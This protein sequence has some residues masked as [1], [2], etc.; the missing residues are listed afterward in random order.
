[1]PTFSRSLFV[2]AMVGVMAL[3]GC[4]KAPSADAADMTMGDANAKV[5]MV[6]Y[7]SA[8]CTHCA[9]FNN[10][11]FPAFK[12]KYIDTGKVHYTFKEF[13]T[14]P[15]EVAAA[16]FLTARCAGK[17]KYFS[18]VDAIFRAQQ[19]MFQTGDM[20]GVLLRVAQSSGMT[21][22]QF[23]ACITDEASLKAL[24]ERVE[25]AIKVDK[26]SGTPTFIINGKQVA[27]G[28]VTLQQLDAAFADA[29]K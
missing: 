26:I 12:A 16:G 22:A 6:E 14:P 25:K 2:A 18:V 7:A 9:A 3:V 8:S 17:D 21:E 1:M 13:L 4:N 20:R 10:D 24:N 27:S 29:S 11:V 19:E 23:N 5:K 28:E 15:V